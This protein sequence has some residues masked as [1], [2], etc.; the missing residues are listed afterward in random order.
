MLKYLNFCIGSFD[1][2]TTINLH[3]KNER[4]FYS[5]KFMAPCKPNILDA[6]LPRKT[7]LAWLSRLG[8]VRLDN[9]RSEY[10]PKDLLIEGIQWNLEYADTEGCRK[11]VFGSGFYPPNW[12]EFIEI[13]D[14]LVPDAELIASDRLDGL[15]IRYH[16]PYFAGSGVCPPSVLPNLIGD[17][18]EYLS[19]DRKSQRFIY[20]INIGTNCFVKHEYYVR[21]GITNLLDWCGEFFSDFS[22][23]DT[24][25]F[26]E[27][28][29]R[30]SI[31]LAHH[32]GEN[33]IFIYDNSLGDFTKRW[34][35]LIDKLVWF[36]S[37]YGQFTLLL[38]TEIFKYKVGAAEYIYC[39]VEFTP[40]GKRYHYRT[41]DSS[42]KLGDRVLVP[43]GENGG[44]SVAV[45][46]GIEYFTA[47]RL[48][49]PLDKAKSIIRKV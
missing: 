31:E 14:I 49:Y 26:N 48:P 29:P 34:R 42:L 16:R 19:V 25:E 39:G 28:K 4:I 10:R 37:F 23:D 45:I 17:Y 46:K 15:K 38:D 22:G 44:E 6:S 1:H 30:L 36:L 33:E 41:E 7:S 5:V 47:D 13:M 3:V 40:G 43:V 8:G 21:G 27:G 18:N 12:D 20:S 32:R 11:R 24:C 35:K 9:W 2:Y